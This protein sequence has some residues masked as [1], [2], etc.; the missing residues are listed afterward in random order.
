M[1]WSSLHFSKALEFRGGLCGMALVRKAC[2]SRHV[3]C[4]HRR[5][6]PR[7][8]RETSMKIKHRLPARTIWK[9]ENKRKTTF[10]LKTLKRP[11][12]K[13][14]PSSAVR[15]RPAANLKSNG[16]WLWLGVLVGSGEVVC[17][18]ANGGKKVTYRLLP[19]KH[20]A[21]DS[22]PRGTEEIRHTLAARIAKGHSLNTF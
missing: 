18:H 13:K 21:I 1:I 5:T 22:K 9:G 2:Q 20:D 8:R 17:T 4:N 15:K 7:P 11:A 3:R 10:N 12:A 16:R 6:Q 19:S 14:R